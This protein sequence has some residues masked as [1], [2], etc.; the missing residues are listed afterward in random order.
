MTTYT[1]L[2]KRIREKDLPNFTRQLFKNR[3]KDRRIKMEKEKKFEVSKEKFLAYKKVQFSGITNMF[4]IKK[5]QE[6][7]DFLCNVPLTKNDCLY[8]MKNYGVLLAEYQ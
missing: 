1:I 5:V 6:L 7:S 3:Q 8:I 4:D 2:N